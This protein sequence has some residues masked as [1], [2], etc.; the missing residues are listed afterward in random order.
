[1]DTTTLAT[2]GA[3]AALAAVALAPLVLALTR[4]APPRG[5]KESALA[6]HRAQLAELDR[7]LAAGRLRPAEHASATLEVQRRLLAVAEAA[8][9]VPARASRLPLLATLVLVPVA[10]LALYLR[11]GHPDM[12]AAPL[13]PRLVEARREAR[14]ADALITTL[15]QRLAQLDP[16]SEMARQGYVLLGNAEA[17][18]AHYAAAAAAW[19]TALAVRWDATL[20]AQ[21]AEA[22]V[23]AGGHVSPATAALFRRALADAPADAPWREL[24]QKRLDEVK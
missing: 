4:Q 5:R 16:K 20:A 6:L 19:Q 1:M 10:A 8:E 3:V 12:P 9:T 11:A 23:R 21:A 22:Q 14:Q 24:A 13:G 15:R 7:E 17:G 2:F 18:R